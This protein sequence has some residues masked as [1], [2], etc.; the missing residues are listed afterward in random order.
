[1]KRVAVVGIPGA[2]KTTMAR[3]IAERLNLTHIELDAYFHKP[4]WEPTESAEFTANIRHAMGQAPD[5]WVMCGAYDSHIDPIRDAECDTIVWLDYSR[6]VVMNRLVRRTVRRAATREELWNGNR[7]PLTN[8]FGWDPATNVIRYA[9][10]NFDK[11]R[12]GY[13]H[14]VNDGAWDRPVVHRFRH[15]RDAE[16]F[17]TGL[18]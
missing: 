13:E 1:M 17:L 12:T 10:V 4:N 11:R 16:R 18:R 5:G 3:G 6:P 14:K 2:G 8:F 7:E 9:W 15:P